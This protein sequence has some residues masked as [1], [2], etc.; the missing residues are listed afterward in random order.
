M[1]LNGSGIRDSARVLHVGPHTGMK[2][3]KKSLRALAGQRER[4]EGGGPDALTGEVRRVE[5]AAGEELGSFVGSK[6]PQRW[7]GHAS[8]HVTGVVLASAVG[9]RADRVFGKLQ[10]LLQPCGLVPF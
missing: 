4:G 10:K 3:V 6:A 2:E 5:A 1:T 7:L 9:S 8:D